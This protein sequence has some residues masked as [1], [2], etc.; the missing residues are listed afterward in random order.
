MGARVATCGHAHK[1]QGSLSTK[2]EKKEA[3]AQGNETTSPE[4]SQARQH[5]SSWSID[6]DET[7]LYVLPLSQGSSTTPRVSFFL[8]LL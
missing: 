8:K 7:E 5:S 1:G 6:A 3:S 2:K 4:L